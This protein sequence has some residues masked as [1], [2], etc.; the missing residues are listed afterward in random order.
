[1]RNAAGAGASTLATFPVVL[2]DNGRNFAPGRSIGRWAF[3]AL[4][5]K[6]RWGR[7]VGALLLAAS[8]GIPLSACR[9]AHGEQV[10]TVSEWRSA[11]PLPDFTT[12]TKSE[13]RVRLAD[14][15]PLDAHPAKEKAK[16]SAR[17]RVRTLKHQNEARFVVLPGIEVVGR[18]R[19]YTGEPLEPDGC[20]ERCL[21]SKGCD[22]FSFERATKICYLVSQITELNSNVGFVSGRLR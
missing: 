12:S 15:A 7:Q 11:I 10:S 6:R 2:L 5:T 18:S 19:S 9:F 13:T 14:R 20:A 17:E 22:G 3:A 16:P 21:A 1:M 8:C 4:L